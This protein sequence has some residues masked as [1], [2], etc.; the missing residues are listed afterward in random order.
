[1]FIVYMISRKQK[2]GH[3][4]NFRTSGGCFCLYVPKVCLLKLEFH[5]PAGI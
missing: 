4:C 5:I 3:E 1:M 2:D